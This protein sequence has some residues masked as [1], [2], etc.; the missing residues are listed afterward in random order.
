MRLRSRLDEDAT[1]LD[2]LDIDRTTARRTQPTEPRQPVTEY[3]DAAGDDQQLEHRVATAARDACAAIAVD[4][5][6]VLRTEPV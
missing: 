6:H 1:G 2:E 5:R 3:V 4:Q